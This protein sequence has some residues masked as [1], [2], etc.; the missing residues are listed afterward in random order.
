[1]FLYR[2]FYLKCC[3][4]RSYKTKSITFQY[5]HQY[6]YHRFS[7]WKH[8]TCIYVSPLWSICMFL[9]HVLGSCV[10]FL[11]PTITSC[12]SWAATSRPAAEPRSSC[13]SCCVSV[14]PT[15]MSRVWKTGPVF[16]RQGN[17]GK[18]LLNIRVWNVYLSQVLCTM[19][20]HFTLF[21]LR[22]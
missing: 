21:F 15:P 8:F 17:G 10:R 1:M 2:C 19:F 3:S 16:S 11:R 13:S 14:S 20:C 6:V 4:A 12:C 5:H 18:S 22:V 9:V 7:A